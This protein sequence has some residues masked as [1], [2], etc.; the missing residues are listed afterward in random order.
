MIRILATLCSLSSGQC[1][2]AMVTN[3]DLQEPLTMSACMVGMPSIAAWMRQFPGYR[4]Q[5]WKC[6]IG[7]APKKEGA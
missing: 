2:E 7:N 6:E 5:S 3:S 1:H 4:L